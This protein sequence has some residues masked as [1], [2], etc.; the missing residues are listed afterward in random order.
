MIR[1]FG[2]LTSPYVRKVRIAAAELG[3]DVDLTVV[4]AWS[5]DNGI[6]ARSPLGKV[7]VIEVDGMT[8]FDSALIIEYLDCQSGNRLIP[9]VGPD[10][11]AVLRW[12]A[13]AHGLIDSAT[14]RTLETRRPAE[15][16]SAA[17]LA[18]EEGRIARVLDSIEAQLTGP[19]PL[20]GDGLTLA[21]FA[22]GVAMGYV[23]FR[24]PH[25]WRATRPKLADW[26]GQ[27][28]Q[29]PSF[30]GTLPPQ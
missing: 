28:S 20:V 7:P 3:L 1:L 18:R 2:S 4:D 16:R 30:Q 22:L 21:D 9:A 25:D 27:I 13:L 6:P 10:R 11:W 8:L 14:I 23:D 15:H 12:H 19:G 26:A 24:Y 17:V 5:P 29:R